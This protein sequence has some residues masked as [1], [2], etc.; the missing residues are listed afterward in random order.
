MKTVIDGVSIQDKRIL[1]VKKRD[2]WI[3]PGGKVEEFEREEDC[4]VREFKEELPGI[5][6][7]IKEF[8]KSFNG[9]T[10]F[11]K[12][13]VLVKVFFIEI[14]GEDISSSAEISGS[15][16]FTKEELGSIKISDIT[17]E[18]LNDLKKN[19]YL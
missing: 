7:S 19:N 18:I 3:L 5:G 16:F 14:I 1:L 17:K 12:R 10:P 9:I 2:T 13:E 11:T 6:I 4:L 15:Q 8:Y